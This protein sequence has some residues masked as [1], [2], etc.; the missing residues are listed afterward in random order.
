[1]QVFHTPGAPPKTG[2]SILADMGST[3]NNRLEA[4]KAAKIK[5]QVIRF[6]YKK[7]VKRFGDAGAFVITHIPRPLQLTGAK[8]PAYSCKRNLPY[9][10]GR[11]ERGSSSALQARGC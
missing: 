7:S 4:R 1:M 2:N 9:Y 3:K 11:D 5:S 10:T 6:V 8:A